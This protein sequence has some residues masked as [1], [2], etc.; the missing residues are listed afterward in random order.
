MPAPRT[1][2]RGT[3]LAAPPKPGPDVYLGLLVLSLLAQVAAAL[4][5]L[6]DYKEY[7]PGKAPKVTPPAAIGGSTPAAPAAP[8]G[9]A[10]GTPAAAPAGPL[11]GALGAQGGA[12]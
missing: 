5:L 10:L 8:G 6:L 9:G 1:S 12:L 7:P 3:D 11:G 2:G 4:F